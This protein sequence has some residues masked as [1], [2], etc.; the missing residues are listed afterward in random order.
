MD[1]LAFIEDYLSEERHEEPHHQ[2][3]QPG[4]A[5]RGTPA[6]RSRCIRA[7]RC[8]FR[9]SKRVQGPIPQDPVWRD[10]PPETP[11]PGAPVRDG[12]LWEV[13]PDREGSGELN[14]R[15]LPPR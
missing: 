3:P 4:D 5:P 12:G 8:A 11:V 10:D 1:P 6:G 15:I 7:N 2:V 14:R 13:C 9:A